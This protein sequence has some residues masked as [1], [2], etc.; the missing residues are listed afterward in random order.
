M[1]SG[2]WYLVKSRS[3]FSFRPSTE[4]QGPSTPLAEWGVPGRY[5]PVRYVSGNSSIV[6]FLVA[7]PKRARAASRTSFW[8][9]M[10]L[11]AP[12]G[13]PR[14]C[15]TASTRGSF[16]SSARCRKALVT[17]VTV[18]MPDSSIDRAT[19]PTDTWHTGQTGT[20]S[21]RSTSCARIR[22]SHPGSSL[23]SL[24][25]DVAPGYE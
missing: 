6:P 25:W 22:S 20:R 14:G 7:V 19:C 21:I 15:L 4:Y 2:T 24:P 17:I 18:G 12:I 13:R 16:I 8:R 1:V 23:R 10:S 11:A 3:W 5:G 9:S